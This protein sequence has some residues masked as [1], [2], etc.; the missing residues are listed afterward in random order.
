MPYIFYLLS[1]LFFFRILSKKSLADLF[2][3]ESVI[4]PPQAGGELLETGLVIVN[5]PIGIHSYCLDTGLKY[6]PN[7]L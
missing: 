6:L 3:I 1:F 7:E 2:S 4:L 5:F